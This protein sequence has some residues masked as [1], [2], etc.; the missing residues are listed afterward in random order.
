MSSALH[1][2]LTCKSCWHA[3]IIQIYHTILSLGLITGW[4]WPSAQHCTQCIQVSYDQRGWGKEWPTEACVPGFRATSLEFMSQCHEL[5]LFI[6]SCFAEGL[7]LPLDTFAKV[8]CLCYVTAS[9][10]YCIFSHFMAAPKILCL[11]LMI[12][13]SLLGVVQLKQSLTV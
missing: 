3:I 9:S 10:I 7:G 11:C 5:C 1:N 12:R 2:A 13:S 8:S 4:Y 6:L